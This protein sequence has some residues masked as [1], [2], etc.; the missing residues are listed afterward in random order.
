VAGVA[1]GAAVGGALV[2]SYSW[3]AGVLAA[4][5]VSAAGAALLVTRRD[6]LARSRL[7]A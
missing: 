2:E 7:A 3:S 1:L 4:V 5:V 6:T